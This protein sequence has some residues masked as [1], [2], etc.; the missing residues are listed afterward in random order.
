MPATRFNQTVEIKA[1]CADHTRIRR[2]LKSRGAKFLSRETQT[3]IFYRVSEG[4]LKLRKSKSEKYLI[5]YQRPDSRGAKQCLVDLYEYNDPGSLDRV[6]TGVLGRRLTVRKRRERW[7]LGSVKFHLDRV[8]KLGTFLEI[9][10][11]GTRG[12]DDPEDLKRTCE[13]WLELCGVSPE[14]LVKVAY[15]DLLEELEACSA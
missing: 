5:G 8:D 1:R 13:E 4:R 9:E 3:D 2:L 14:D 7:L 11:L 6:L 12:K 10:V 15:A